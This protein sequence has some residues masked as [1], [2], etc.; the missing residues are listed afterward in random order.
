MIQGGF[1]PEFDEESISEVMIPSSLFVADKSRTW[2]LR[3]THQPAGRDYPKEKS[4]NWWWFTP[5]KWTNTGLKEPFPSPYFSL[6]L[7]PLISLV[8][9]DYF[10]QPALS[11]NS[12]VFFFLCESLKMAQ[13]KGEKLFKSHTVL[14]I[15]DG[16]CH[17]FC[18]REICRGVNLWWIKSVRPETPCLKF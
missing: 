11:R 18:F 1:L 6:P 8:K 10:L 7:S 3:K 2:C 13:F 15:A 14:K 17:V 12:K 16:W 9:T 4:S 5:N